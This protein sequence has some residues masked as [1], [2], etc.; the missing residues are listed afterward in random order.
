MLATLLGEFLRVVPRQ[1]KGQKAMNTR[2]LALLFVFVVA[3]FGCGDVVGINDPVDDSTGYYGSVSVVDFGDDNSIM[4]APGDPAERELTLRMTWKGGSSE[5]LLDGKMIRFHEGETTLSLLNANGVELSA[6]L[7]ITLA[8]VTYFVPQQAV[9]REQLV[10]YES[11]TGDPGVINWGTFTQELVHPVQVVRVAIPGVFSAA[12][13]IEINHLAQAIETRQ[14][15]DSQW[16]AVL[17]LAAQY[18]YGIRARAGEV[19]VNSGIQVEQLG[20]IFSSDGQYHPYAGQS[21]SITLENGN[22]ASGYARLA[23]DANANM[24]NPGDP[25]S[26]PPLEPGVGGNPGV[27]S[28]LGDVLFGV[29]NQPAVVITYPANGAVLAAGTDQLRVVADIRNHPGNV[30]WSLRATNNVARGPSVSSI[31]QGAILSDLVDGGEYELTAQLI[32]ED[33]N[34]LV[35]N[36]SHTVRF[37]IAEPAD[38]VG[39]LPRE[40]EL[41]FVVAANDQVGRT[42]GFAVSRGEFIEIHRSDDARRSNAQL[43]IN[44]EA[45]TIE[46]W[47]GDARYGPFERGTWVSKVEIWQWVD[48][49]FVVNDEATLQANWSVTVVS[50]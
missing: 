37:S 14:D 18:S 24:T 25:L 45:T 50:V 36:I 38:Q 49:E 5:D 28:G 9:S 11:I 26:E 7:Q 29:P 30:H 8:G 33:Q 20:M 6:G 39:E 32:D 4:A 48:A 46:L 1:E 23:F 15:L 16:F 21:R 44:G 43:F 2:S 35:P 42:E 40:K 10:S 22:R 47:P 19:V 34:P 27:D 13:R 41:S 31:W 17:P 12:P 3:T